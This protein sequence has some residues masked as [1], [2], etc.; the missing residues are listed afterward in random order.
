MNFGDTKSNEIEVEV[1]PGETL[2]LGA[3]FLRSPTFSRS[4]IPHFWTGLL[5][6]A[7]FSRLFTGKLWDLH[8]TARETPEKVQL[9]GNEPKGSFLVVTVEPK[10]KLFLRL[11]HLAAYAFGPGGG[12][13]T[14]L[15]LVSPS[16]WILKAISA[17][18][19]RGP[20]TLVFY[21]V[22][23]KTT[24]IEAGGHSFADQLLAFDA[25]TPFRL[26]G[27]LPEGH[28]PAA[29]GTNITSSTVDVEFEAPATVVKK[30]TRTQNTNR[31][32]RLWR[33]LFLG[34]LGGWLVEQAVMRPWRITAFPS[35][36]T[37]TGKVN[38]CSFPLGDFRPKHL[39]HAASL[40]SGVARR[41]DSVGL[42]Q[43][44]LVQ[45]TRAMW[46]FPQLTND[47]L[48]DDP[49][50]SLVTLFAD[51]YR[52]IAADPGFE[53]VKSAMPWCFAGA[54]AD[55]GNGFVFVPARRMDATAAKNAVPAIVFLHG[56]GGS[57]LWNLWALKVS[58][59]DHVILMPSGGIAWPDQDAAVVRRYVRG[60]IED[61]EAKH[62]ITID[63]P[64]LFS[65]S[66][67]GPTGFRLA[68]DYPG[69]F[70]GYV[71]IAT[72]AQEPG[73]LPVD[74][75]FPIL[76]VNGHKDER[77]TIAEATDSFITLKARGA[78]VRQKVL[79]GADHFFFLSERTRLQE[80]IHDF[81]TEQF[82][83]EAVRL[84]ERERVRTP[85]L[86][87]APPP[88]PPITMR[89][90]VGEYRG[91]RPPDDNR[92]ITFS[93]NE[94]GTFIATQQSDEIS[95]EDGYGLVKQGRGRWYL[96]DGTLTVSQEEVATPFAWVEEAFGRSAKA[97]WIN[98]A[99]IE[100]AAEGHFRLGGEYNPLIKK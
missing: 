9:G 76:M 74:R 67:G 33:L 91:W 65:L 68:S 60:L 26:H 1:E 69:D 95:L 36:A 80:I 82:R 66:Q 57:L 85:A 79:A 34:L 20:A 83:I 97:V 43:L 86:P 10:H 70:K 93:F 2:H 38:N 24:E 100:R 84:A 35:Q 11:R 37:F 12:F 8:V 49:D 42:E 94:D 50:G 64:W 73:S 19:V 14:S 63:R 22:E 32:S 45:G 59:P 54:G 28:D 52:G 56:Y 5:P 77:V 3:E 81:M 6:D 25:T 72:W 30:T 78:D 88:P 17:V 96:R 71:A 40:E 47:Q 62:S 16:R 23:L 61:V 89:D 53:D 75:E 87:E 98:D 15:N 7:F 21:G 51:A 39:D 55:T 31:L 13:C 48:H 29:H 90:L 27:L 58:F 99:P 41:L 44:A 92:T 18:M 4:T 46:L